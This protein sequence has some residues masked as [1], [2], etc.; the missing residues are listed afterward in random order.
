MSCYSIHSLGDKI[1]NQIQVDFFF[2]EKRANQEVSNFHRIET[3]GKCSSHFEK[4]LQPRY[5]YDENWHHLSKQVHGPAAAMWSEFT[6]SASQHQKVQSR[7]KKPTYLCAPRELLKNCVCHESYYLDYRINKPFACS[8]CVIWVLC[9]V[10]V[11]ST[12]YIRKGLCVCVLILLPTNNKVGKSNHMAVLSSTTC[13]TWFKLD[14]TVV[15][16]QKQCL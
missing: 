16:L 7:K 8:R 15:L 12:Y 5:A 11:I 4:I 1:K 2:L 13:K 3:T 10:H 6:C 9:S 14:G